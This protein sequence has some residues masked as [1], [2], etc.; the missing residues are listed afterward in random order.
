MP[1]YRRV[2]PAIRRI[3]KRGRFAAPTPAPA[4]ANVGQNKSSPTTLRS[5]CNL[6]RTPSE[7]V[8]LNDYAASHRAVREMRA[9]DL[10]LEGTTLRLSKCKSL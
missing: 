4:T 6:P 5:S 2:R 7:T 8:T 10:L 3:G 1:R 9:E